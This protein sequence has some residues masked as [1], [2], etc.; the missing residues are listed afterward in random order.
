[1]KAKCFLH[2]LTAILHRS[3]RGDF[4]SFSSDNLLFP[5]SIW[6]FISLFFFGLLFP[7]TIWTF[8]SLF[9]F[10]F[11]FAFIS[12]QF[13]A[14]THLGF[15]QVFFCLTSHN[16]MKEKKIGKQC[17][18]EF[19]GFKFNEPIKSDKSNILLLQFSDQV[20]QIL[21]VNSIS[22]VKSKK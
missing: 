22:K 4:F 21:G 20:C 2:F 10:L 12:F 16:T 3:L 17:V 6:T 11:W 14:V 13:F 1:M 18:S 7:F 19:F 15:F 8:F 9:L 5:I